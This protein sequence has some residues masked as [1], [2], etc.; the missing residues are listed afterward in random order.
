MSTR[1]RRPETGDGLFILGLVGRAGS[2]KTTVA[3]ALEAGGA[4]VIEADRIGHE[5][6]DRD[7]EVRAALIA[8]YGADVYRADGALDRARVAARVFREPA[9]RERLNQIVHPK[10]MARI[11][12]TIVEL[13]RQGWRGVV[14]VDGKADG[15]AC[16][17]ALVRASWT[18][19]YRACCTTVGRSS[20]R[21]ATVSATSWL[22]VRARSTS[23]GR[24]AASGCGA[25]AAPS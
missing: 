10:I 6:T 25:R 20:G 14:V 12:E 15:E 3:R 23:S 11:R 19:R 9:A 7:P 21:P 24:R 5:I 2:G 17:A 4:R 13:V 18:A 16:L 8:D 22:A 1:V